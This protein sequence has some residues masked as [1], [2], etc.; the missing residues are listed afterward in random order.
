MKYFFFVLALIHA[1]V[2]L[3]AE[4]ASPPAQRPTFAPAKQSSKDI[5]VVVFGKHGQTW[6]QQLKD[7]FDC[8]VPR[9]NNLELMRKLPLPPAKRRVKRVQASVHCET[10]VS[11]ASRG[12]H[13]AVPAPTAL[14]AGAIS[15]KIGRGER[16]SKGLALP[17]GA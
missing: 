9:S 8:W 13:V 7:K 2:P 3:S 15:L 10:P 12:P 1:P 4:S 11:T 14:G 5:V 6:D 17:N 16:L